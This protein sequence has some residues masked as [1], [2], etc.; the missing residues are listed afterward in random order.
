MDGLWG[1]IKFQSAHILFPVANLVM[2]T[3][4]AKPKNARTKRL[5]ESREPQ[6]HEHAKTAMFLKAS[7]CPEVLRGLISDLHTLKKPNSIFYS[8]KNENLKPF[9]DCSSIEFFSKKTDAGLFVIGYNSKKRPYSLAM[10]RVF[11]HQV[12]DMIELHCKVDAFRPMSSFKVNTKMHAILMSVSCF[13]GI[14]SDVLQRG[15]APDG[16]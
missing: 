2:P 11:D 4:I 8:R 9:E 5:M 16:L 13:S 7:T 14:G 3:V 6:V 1:K 15:Q 10:G 12:L